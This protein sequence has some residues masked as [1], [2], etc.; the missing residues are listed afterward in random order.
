M[1]ELHPGINNQTDNNS[2]AEE[3]KVR[4]KN[5]LKK[6]HLQCDIRKLKITKKRR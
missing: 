4:V 5:F 3:L 6:K 2:L 1:E